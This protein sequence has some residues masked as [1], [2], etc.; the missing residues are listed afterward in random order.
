MDKIEEEWRNNEWLGKEWKRK[1]NFNNIDLVVLEW[2]HA[3]IAKGY[4]PLTLLLCKK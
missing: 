2:F 3:K 4:S 1:S